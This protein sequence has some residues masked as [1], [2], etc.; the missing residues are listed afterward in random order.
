MFTG[1]IDI[2]LFPQIFF[3]LRGSIPCMIATKQ[4]Y[5]NRHIII[6]SLIQY[7]ILLS[8]TQSYILNLRYTEYWIHNLKQCSHFGVTKV[9]GGNTGLVYRVAKKC[10]ATGALS[11][12]I[13]SSP[14]YLAHQPRRP[15]A[16]W[17]GHSAEIYFI[18]LEHISKYYR[19]KRNIKIRTNNRRA[20]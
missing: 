12:P 4:F 10:G 19:L 6:L 17:A 2:T 5:T 16:G 20:N 3:H 1:E 9:K 14:A 18:K 8:Q 13:R 15:Q 7:L 11:P